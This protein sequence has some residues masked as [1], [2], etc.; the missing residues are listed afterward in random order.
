MNISKSV[1]SNILH[2]FVTNSKRIDN[3]K[4]DQVA[5]QYMQENKQSI[6][7]SK[8]KEC[9]VDHIDINTECGDIK[10]EVMDSTNENKSMGAYNN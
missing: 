5:Y 3:V 9:K 2:K 1:N 10:V 4:V 7:A 6:K 8:R